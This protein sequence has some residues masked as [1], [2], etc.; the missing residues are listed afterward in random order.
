M[1]MTISGIES[2]TTLQLNITEKEEAGRVY[3]E[4]DTVEFDVVVVDDDETTDLGVVVTGGGYIVIIETVADEFNPGVTKVKITARAQGSSTIYILSKEGNITKTIDIRVDLV[5]GAVTF[6]P[7][8]VSVIKQG[9]SLDL[10][11]INSFLKFYP[12]DT[13][14]REVKY[15][16][17]VPEDGVLM[18]NGKTYTYAGNNGLKYADILNDV[19]VTFEDAVFPRDNETGKFVVTVKASSIYN[20]KV[21]DYADFEVV[22]I[23]N[24]IEVYINSDLY[25]DELIQLSKNRDG[26]YEIVLAN[27]SYDLG[28]TEVNDYLYSRNLY[29]VMNYGGDND[30][31]YIVQTDLISDS[32]HSSITISDISAAMTNQY[33]GVFC[34]QS[35]KEGGTIVHTFNVEHKSFVGRFT[36]EIKVMI[37][38]K[39]F[40]RN[41]EIDSSTKGEDGLIYVYDTYST[42]VLGSSINVSLKPYYE[43]QKY[44]ICFPSGYLDSLSLVRS[45]GI[46]INMAQYDPITSIFDLTDATEC[47]VGATVYLRHKYIIVPP[48]DT[49]TMYILTYFDLASSDYQEFKEEYFNVYPIMQSIDIKIVKGM[50]DISI[51]STNY[52]L[53]VTNELYYTTGIRILELPQGNSFENTIASIDYSNDSNICYIDLV[54]ENPICSLLLKINDEFREGGVNITI[55]L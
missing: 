20:D 53:D 51:E 13:S 37:I 32:N 54:Y 4:Y 11:D 18:P 29:F 7:E 52:S 38:V 8:K 14:Q 46:T 43:G 5:I 26:C 12:K 25:D 48:V 40:T 21:C 17:V 30:T 15:E 27:P 6:K 36:Q 42:G 9:S 41:I 49:V 24:N 35:V 3:R 2:D 28:I 45:S 31:N 23:N 44:Y 19:L 47:S 55:T 34:I 50:T 39:N 1:S 22:N 16:I 33:M 10:S